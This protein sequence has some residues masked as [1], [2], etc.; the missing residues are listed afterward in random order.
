[1]CGFLDQ[2]KNGH[3]TAP[4]A[5]CGVVHNIIII[6]YYIFLYSRSNKP[7]RINL[8]HNIIY[9][10]VIVFFFFFAVGTK[11]KNF[12][13]Q[14]FAM[15]VHRDTNNIISSNNDYRYCYTVLIIIII[16]V[17]A[18]TKRIFTA[19]RGRANRSFGRTVAKHSSAVS[20]GIIS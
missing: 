6:Q 10:A 13:C 15:V 1:V 4:A 14:I 5:L 7:R 3:A 11:K 8:L 17:S 12:S 19:C 16:T 20:I 18:G 2:Y 9:S